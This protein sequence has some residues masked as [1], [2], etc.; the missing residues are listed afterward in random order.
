MRFFHS[1][2]ATLVLLSA[3]AASAQTTRPTSDQSWRPLFNGKDLTGWYT[4]L[5]DDAK[6]RDTQHVFQVHDGMIHIYKSVPDGEQAQFGYIATT[7]DFA[8]YRIRFQYKWG[9]K[10]FGSRATQRRDAGLLFHVYGADGAR[11]GGVWPYSIECQV[12]ENDTG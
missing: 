2:A 10:R 1:L 12:M 5:K 11:N 8:D 3:T 4:Y 7:E 6:D 9:L